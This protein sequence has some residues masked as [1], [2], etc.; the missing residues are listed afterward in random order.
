LQG[1]LNYDI[2]KIEYSELFIEM[3]AGPYAGKSYT[4]R[5]KHIDE[6]QM[7]EGVETAQEV[8]ERIHQ[9]LEWLKTLPQNNIV[10]V[11]HGGVGRMV[12]TIAEDKDT[13]NFL[14]IERMDNS[15]IYEF[16]I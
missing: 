7:L 3:R 14:K 12:Q 15:A 10:V 16:E 2:S 13:H 5:Q 6:G 11:S 9:A 1:T 8:H 4:Y